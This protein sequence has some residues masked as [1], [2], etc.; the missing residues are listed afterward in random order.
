MNIQYITINTI[1]NT[2]SMLFIKLSWL[3]IHLTLL[4]INL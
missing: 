4:N 2:Y 1:Y 3:C